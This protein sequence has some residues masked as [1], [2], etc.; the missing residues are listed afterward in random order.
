MVV[1]TEGSKGRPNDPKSSKY[2]AFALLRKTRFTV[3]PACSKSC[4]IA[5]R[6]V[7]I[8]RRVEPRRSVERIRTQAERCRCRGFGWAFLFGP[9]GASIAVQVLIIGGEICLKLA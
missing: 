3:S 1:N 9:W 6:L 4:R 5:V 8:R 7:I 2:V